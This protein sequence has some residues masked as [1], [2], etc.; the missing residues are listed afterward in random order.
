MNPDPSKVWTSD[1]LT[2]GAR[3]QP[4]MGE[5]SLWRQCNG[6]VSL[7]RQAPRRVSARRA[8]K[9][10]TLP[11]AW[12]SGIASGTLVRA[13]AGHQHVTWRMALVS[14]DFAARV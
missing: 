5:P 7:G 2:P 12:L 13:R 8:K 11:V 10:A 9:R 4:Q 3:R 6:K 1:G 14:F